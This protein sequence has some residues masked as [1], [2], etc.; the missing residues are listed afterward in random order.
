M[1]PVASA[2]AISCPPQWAG[3]ILGR[4]ISLARKLFA[5]RRFALRKGSSLNAPISASSVPGTGTI[6]ASS[7]KILKRAEGG[8]RASSPGDRS[9]LVGNDRLFG[10]ESY[11]TL[12]LGQRAYFNQMAAQRE[13]THCTLTCTLELASRSL[14]L[15]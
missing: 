9:R 2:G 12:F 10:N 14:G 8:R 6:L 4:E 11:A 15:K 1:A 5:L 7:V 13:A 3:Q